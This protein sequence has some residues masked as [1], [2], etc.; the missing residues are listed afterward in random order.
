MALIRPIPTKEELTLV[1]S[2]VAPSNVAYGQSATQTVNCTS[3]TNYGS[4]TSDDFI[5]SINNLI[6]TINPNAS[7]MSNINT[8]IGSKS[9]DASTGI[10]TITTQAAAGGN[11]YLGINVDVYCK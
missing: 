10:L 4:K 6:H 9:Y 7:Q 5:L 3:V 8:A 11:V 1:A 2:N